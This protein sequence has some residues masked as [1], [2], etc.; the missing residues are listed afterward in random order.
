MTRRALLVAALL[1]VLSA[2]LTVAAAAGPRRRLAPIPTRHAVSSHAPY[3]SR[4]C[5]TCHQSNDA[6]H[7]GAVTRAGNELCY[8][9]HDDFRAPR[10]VSRHP[11]TRS[12]CTTCH[13][14]HNA[15]SRALLD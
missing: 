7:P 4:E 2:L 14:P 13:N 8:D 9:C 3:A 11:A 6:R 15:R 12:T 10:R 5:G 1:F